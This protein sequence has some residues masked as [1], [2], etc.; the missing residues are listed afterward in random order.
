M[1]LRDP[2]VNAIASVVPAGLPGAP[3]VG[4]KD[5]V[6]VTTTPAACGNEWSSSRETGFDTVPPAL[7]TLALIDARPDATGP[8]GS[9]AVTSTP[10]TPRI[11][12][13]PG[14]VT[15]TAGFVVSVA[16]AARRLRKKCGP[17][18]TPIPKA[19]AFAASLMS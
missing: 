9:N 5:P 16:L 11:S 6:A 3:P 4:V 10:I 1:P 14:F 18:P 15:E 2:L 13:A 17:S 19:G 8:F 7:L 12:S